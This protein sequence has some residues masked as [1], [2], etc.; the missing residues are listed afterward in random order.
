MNPKLATR[1]SSIVEVRICGSF[2]IG[3]CHI[4][5]FTENF[6]SYAKVYLFIIV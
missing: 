1:F 6:L 2:L 3:L 4:I 5:T